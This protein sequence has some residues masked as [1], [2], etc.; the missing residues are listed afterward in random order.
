MPPGGR[1]AVGR[2]YQRR[3]ELLS[4]SGV[5]WMNLLIIL[6][7]PP[8]LSHS[9]YY[10]GGEQDVN[11]LKKIPTEQ[12]VGEL[13]SRG[14]LKVNTEVR[15]PYQLGHKLV[16]TGYGHSTEIKAQTVLVVPPFSLE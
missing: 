8:N 3:L 14:C 2:H 9:Q 16:Q 5:A 15:S 6:I 11:K 1:A 7:L 10:K 12:L 4:I 13:L